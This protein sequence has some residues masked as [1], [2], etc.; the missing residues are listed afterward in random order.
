MTDIFQNTS[1]ID[2]CFACHYH[3]KAM[4]LYRIPIRREKI[5]TIPDLM[6]SIG[7]PV[8]RTENR[9]NGVYY[10]C[11][12]PKRSKKTWAFCITRENEG[13]PRFFTCGLS[14]LSKQVVIS[15][16]ASGLFDRADTSP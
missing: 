11:V 14:Q 8:V 10:F 3:P 6:K 1:R 12:N 15:L 5:E 16:N 2:S 4:G 7:F 13:S 9:E